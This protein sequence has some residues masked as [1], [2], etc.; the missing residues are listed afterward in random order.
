V[1]MDIIS[2]ERIVWT[3]ISMPNFREK[4]DYAF[5]A[6]TELC[7]FIMV[8]IPSPIFVRPPIFYIEFSKLVFGSCQKSLDVYGS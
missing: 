6:V 8:D 3:T 1:A 7:N 4:F 5:W 2:W